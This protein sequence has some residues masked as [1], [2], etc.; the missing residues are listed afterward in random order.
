MSRT[1]LA[2]KMQSAP[3]APLSIMKIC[4]LPRGAPAK[5]AATCGT[6][7]TISKGFQ[8]HVTGGTNTF[9]SYRRTGWPPGPTS[10]TA[11]LKTSN[12]TIPATGSDDPLTMPPTDI[13]MNTGASIVMGPSSRVLPRLKLH[14]TFP[15]T[16][17]TQTSPKLRRFSRSAA[18]PEMTNP[19][20]PVSKMNGPTSTP[21]IKGLTSTCDDCA[22][23]ML[24]SGR[25][26]ASNRTLPALSNR[27]G[28]APAPGSTRSGPPSASPGRV[29]GLR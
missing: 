12:P 28:F 20:A 17:L 19:L 24:T 8:S 14:G 23:S 27:F 15:A 4:G 10:R 21:S 9:G 22:S 16:P 13:S 3:P 26:L 18:A 2:W 6:L 1:A 25:F 11:D 5:S 29:P 7:L